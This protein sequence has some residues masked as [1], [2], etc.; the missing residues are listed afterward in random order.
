MSQNGHLDKAIQDDHQSIMLV[1]LWSAHNIQSYNILVNVTIT[2]DPER[3]T[4]TDICTL[5]HLSLIKTNS[6]KTF[7]YLLSDFYFQPLMTVGNFFIVNLALADFC[8]TGFI[9]PFSIFGKIY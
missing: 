3:K 5:S 7:R 2:K 8:V 9:N 1:T 6:L 4:R